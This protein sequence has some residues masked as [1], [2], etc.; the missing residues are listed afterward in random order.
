M[1]RACNRET[2]RRGGSQPRCTGRHNSQFF[3]TTLRSGLAIRN[4]GHQLPSCRTIRGSLPG[5][6]SCDRSLLKSYTDSA[7]FSQCHWLLPQSGS[8]CTRGPRSLA[9]LRI[10]F[11]GTQLLSM[12]NLS[13]AQTQLQLHRPFRPTLWGAK[14]GA[15]DEPVQSRVCNTAK[16]RRYAYFAPA[17]I[18]LHCLSLSLQVHANKA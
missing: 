4:Q 9:L 12:L 15:K 16:S 1:T 18:A 7:H 5:S 11:W 6:S 17:L 3:R 10:I 14:R 2:A 13:G 8:A